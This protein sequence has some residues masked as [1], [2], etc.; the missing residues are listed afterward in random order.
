MRL[1]CQD[2]QILRTCA[3]NISQNLDIP[4]VKLAVVLVNHQSQA[5][6]L[7]HVEMSS[8]AL[9]EGNFFSGQCQ[10][11]NPS[12]RQSNRPLLHRFSR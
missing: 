4:E 6:P 10:L 8:G 9:G 7:E 11:G 3:M 1:H 12:N 2:N 5:I